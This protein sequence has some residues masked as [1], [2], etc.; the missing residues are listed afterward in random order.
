MFFFLMFVCC[1]FFFFCSNTEDVVVDDVDEVLVLGFDEPLCLGEGLLE[2]EFAGKL[3]EF[4]C[5]FYRCTYVDKEV[6]KNAA[7]TQFI[8]TCGCKEVFPLLG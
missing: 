7:V 1:D 4:L 3:N 8:R 5:G 6:E 2:I